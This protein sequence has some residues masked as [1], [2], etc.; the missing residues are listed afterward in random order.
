[1]QRLALVLAAFIISMIMMVHVGHLEGTKKKG[2][3]I[4]ARDKILGD[5]HHFETIQNR[6]VK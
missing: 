6:A 2:G 3:F 1:M 5:I 4:A